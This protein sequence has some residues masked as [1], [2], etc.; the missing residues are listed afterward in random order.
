MLGET[1]RVLAAADDAGRRHYATTLFREAEAQTGSC[2]SR[3]TIYAANL[4][5][6]LMVH[7]FVRYLQG[8][9]PDPDAL[10]NLAAGEYSLFP[11][12]V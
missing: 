10:F 3:S 2:T 1:V 5:A 8:R 6:A 7:Q 12:A 4:A 11:V 9:G